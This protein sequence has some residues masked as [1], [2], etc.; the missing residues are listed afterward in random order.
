V[1]YKR[2]K[3]IKMKTLT[4]RQKETLH[5]IMNFFVTRGYSPSYRDIKMEFGYYSTN[6]VT[7]HLRYL[8]KKEYISIK[9]DGRSRAIVV[10][11]NPAGQKVRLKFER[12]FEEE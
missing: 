8:E 10:L 11:A 7:D 3:E 5:Y 2:E 4:D 9:G 1:I 6:A 12:V